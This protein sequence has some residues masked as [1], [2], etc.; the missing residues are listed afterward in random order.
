MLTLRLSFIFLFLSVF[1]RII[2]QDVEFSVTAP[3]VVAV[4]EQFRLVYKLNARPQE[5][6]PPSFDNF[7][8]LA[9]PSTSTSS[10]IQIINGQMT[11]TYEFSY[12]YILEATTE[13]KFTIEPAIA[14]VSKKEHKSKPISIEVV[15]GT[16][17]QSSTG[18]QQQQRQGAQTQPQTDQGADEMFVAV[19]FDKKTAYRGQ[20]ILATVKIYTRQNISGF[21]EVKF[22]AF[23]GFWSQEVETPSNV[24][25]QRV[26]L[27]GRIYNM[28]ILKKYLLFPQRTGDIEIEPFEIV[29]LTQQRGGRPQSMFD[30]FF[31]TFQTVRKRLASKTNTLKIRDLPPNAP[32]SF[33]GAVGKF[34]IEATFDKT[35]I[36]TNE[37]ANLKVRVAGS[38]NLRLIETPKVQFPGGFEVFDPKTTDRINTTLQGATGSKIFEYVAIPRAPGNFDM[39]TLEFTYFDPT[40]EKY[41]TLRSKP[42][43][44]NVEA[45]GSEPTNLQMVGFGREDVRF[46]GQDIRFIK[47]EGFILSITG[48]T[49]FASTQY[50]ILLISL[51]ILFAGA[52]VWLNQMQKLKGNIALI[53]TRKANKMARKRL[54]MAQKFLLESNSEKFYDELLRALWGYV[55]DKLSIPIANLTTDSAKETLAIHNVSEF[56][57]EEFTK[58][59]S[60]CEFARYAP[61]SVPSQMN[62]LYDSALTLIARLEGVIEK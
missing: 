47:T 51:L 8:I 27:D 30:E 29:V 40:L 17:G 43:S 9:G 53:R 58:I 36:K 22:P 4:G 41:V 21:D 52:F 54:K 61:K 2:A 23:N 7:Y 14:I 24:N 44:L 28:G 11:Q 42:L 35:E 38:G 6:N 5:F 1:S 57:I 46:I 18:R 34:N 49:L 37:A 59:V 26:N 3:N 25:F 62:V 20:P 15:K 48:T 33:T 16:T 45:D 31:G 32:P 10:S 56:D 60:T 13:G 55:S 19:E 39:G 50:V 12:T